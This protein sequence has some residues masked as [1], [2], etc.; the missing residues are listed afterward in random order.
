MTTRLSCLFTPLLYGYLQYLSRLPICLSVSS[1]CSPIPIWQTISPAGCLPVS[2]TYLSVTPTWISVSLSLLSVNPSL[3][4]DYLS[5]LPAYLSLLLAY[6][7]LLPCL[8]VSCLFFCLSYLATCLCC[9]LMSGWMDVSACLLTTP[10]TP[11]LTCNMKNC[12]IA[13][14]SPARQLIFSS[15]PS[16]MFSGQW[17]GVNRSITRQSGGQALTRLYSNKCTNNQSVQ[18]NMHIRGKASETTALCKL[19]RKLQT[20]TVIYLIKTTLK[21]VT[22]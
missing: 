20:K 1:D 3:L 11:L 6:M 9:E 4:T 14:E 8:S 2:P 12:Q 10:L 7:S 18:R 19:F 13:E 17:R 16:W 22:N 15:S 5:F 21:I